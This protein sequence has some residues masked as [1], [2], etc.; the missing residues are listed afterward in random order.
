MFLSSSDYHNNFSEFSFA[1]AN[2]GYAFSLSDKFAI[3]LLTQGGFKIGD[4]SNSSL[5]F[6]LGGYGNNFINNFI[7]FYGYDYISLTGD[8]FVKG[9][10][11]MDYEL[12]KK[13]HLIFS[14]NYANVGIDLFDK[15]DWFTSPD[16]SGYALG[17]SLESILGPIEI[18]YTWS[19]E[20]KK[21]IWFFNLGFWF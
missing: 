10:I 18:K 15:G 21:S 7:S 9:T 2:I 19:P 11:N 12:Y 1:K 3:N 16:F 6:A 20:V 14:T 5:N 4:D 13:H 8:G 17:Y